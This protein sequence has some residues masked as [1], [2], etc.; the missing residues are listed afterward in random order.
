V[1]WDVKHTHRGDTHAIIESVFRIR[2]SL[3]SGVRWEGWDE[4]KLQARLINDISL[5]IGERREGGVVSH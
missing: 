3:S 2:T 5:Y 4:E 1:I